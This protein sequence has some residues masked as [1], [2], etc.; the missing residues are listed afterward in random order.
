[1]PLDGSGCWCGLGAGGVSFSGFAGGSLNLTPTS[2]FLRFATACLAIAVIASM[3]GVDTNSS[4]AQAAAEAVAGVS[5]SR[6]GR[7]SVFV[8]VSFQAAAF[9]HVDFAAGG[10]AGSFRVAVLLSPSVIFVPRSNRT[11]RTCLRLGEVARGGVMARDVTGDDAL[12]D[13]STTRRVSRCSDG[14]AENSLRALFWWRPLGGDGD[15]LSDGVDVP[16]AAGV[17]SSSESVSTNSRDLYL[18]K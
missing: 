9:C 17:V 10:F 7:G 11:L 14:E 4:L 18:S 13:R 2:R 12:G 5:V 1:L 8:V 16:D 15:R 6:A 3:F